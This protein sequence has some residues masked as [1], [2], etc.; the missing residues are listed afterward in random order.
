MAVIQTPEV[1]IYQLWR[2]QSKMKTCT[3]CKIEK[4]L[5]EFHRWSSTLDGYQYNC[6]SC[7]AAYRKKN[8]QLPHNLARSKAYHFKNKYCI[9]LEEYELLLQEQNNRCAICKQ[10]ESSLGRSGKILPLA[11]DHCHLTGRVRGLLCKNCNISLGN[12]EDSVE[13]LSSAISYLQRWGVEK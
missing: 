4:P 13:R 5:S 6:K 12:M 10:E 11:V 8:D 2:F 9:S 3:K 7:K 1:S